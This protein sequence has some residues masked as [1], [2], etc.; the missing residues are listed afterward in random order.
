M[1]VQDVM[2]KR[3]VTVTRDWRVKQAV[4][5]LAERQMSSLPVVDGRGRVCGIVSEADLIRNAFAQDS[6]L[7]ERPTNDPRGVTPLLVSEVM[8]SPAVTVRE[9]NDLA[10]VVELMTRRNLKSL[11]VVD[12]EGRVVGTVSRSDVIRVRAR[13][14]RLLEQ[15]VGDLMLQLEHHDW[16]VEVHDGIVDIDGPGTQLDRSI[17]QVAANTVAGVVNVRVY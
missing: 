5:L 6:R 4:M 12:D 10:D 7:H 16:L 2:T 11:P 3:P 9:R 8:T 1:L 14:D 17:A 15:E 13:S